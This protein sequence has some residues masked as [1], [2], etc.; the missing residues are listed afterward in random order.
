M[1]ELDNVKAVGKLIYDLDG[2]GNLRITDATTL[3]VL[4][5]LDV[6]PSAP[7]SSNDDGGPPQ[8]SQL[9]VA[10]GK[11]AIFGTET[12]VSKPVKGDPS[13]TQATTSFMTVTFVDAT[14]PAKPTITDR[15]RVEGSL[16]SARLVGGE[17]RL[18]TTANMADLGFVM[19]TTPTSVA[20]ALDRNRRSV[21]SSTAADWI[22]D[23]QRKG[24]KPTPLVPCDRVHVPDTFSGVAMTSMVTFPLG[25][26][27]FDPNGTSILAPATTLYAGLDK[28]A[29]SSQVWVDPIDQTR[30]KF[31]NWQTAIHEFT[32]A[33]GAAPDYVGSGIVD[34]STVGQFA[35][36]E[37]GKALGVVTTKG[38]PWEQDPKAAVDLTVLSP[39][40][41]GKLTDTAKVDNL[42]DGKGGVTAV[43]FVDGRVLVSDGTFGRRIDVIDVS[44]PAKPRR[45]G[46][47]A[48]YGSVGY[49]HPLPDHQAL[50]IGSRTDVVGEGKNQRSRSWVRAQLLDVSN[51]DAPRIVNTWEQP[52]SADQVG[53]DHHAFTYWPDRHLAMWGLQDT[54]GGTDPGPNHAAVLSTD[55]QVNQVALPVANKPNAVAAPCATFDV[56]SPDAQQ[57]IGPNGVVLQCAD[58]SQKDGRVASLPVQP[59]RPRHRRP[60]RTRG[61][62]RTRRTSS[63]RP[64]RNPRSPVSSW[65]PAGRSCSPTRRWRR[66]TR[67]RSSPPPSPTTRRTSTTATRSATPAADAAAGARSRQHAVGGFR[68]PA[69]G[70]GCHLG[71]RRGEQR[72]HP[73]GVVLEHGE[74]VG[75][76]HGSAATGRPRRRRPSR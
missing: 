12:E 25:T 65:C 46:S 32:F 7:M 52:W 36:G 74:D 73:V 62:G 18:V 14:D 56:A 45:A 31:E 63:A 53:Q 15:V 75:L 30:L 47:L 40:G 17:I 35:F 3:H 21:A 11:V 22:P 23:W 9:L 13:A 69:V 27:R 59:G 72:A 48:L 8:V 66:W 67:R 44:D 70:V 37:I 42:S 54:Q 38:T 28:V 26:G 2:K 57:L 76:V 43:R 60:V 6:T 29:I 5:T 19:P 24:G 4:S 55:G 68:A 51:A 16:V 20:K 61:E 34:G 71:E 64:R 41:K 58:K 49:F 39:D 33:K 50:L 1:D 10:N